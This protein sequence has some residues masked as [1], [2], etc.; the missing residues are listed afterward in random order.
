MILTLMDPAI[1]NM[2]KGNC[3]KWN[4]MMQKKVD[5]VIN[6]IIHIHIIIIIELS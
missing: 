3:E 6:I 1:L 2:F 4:W 5:V